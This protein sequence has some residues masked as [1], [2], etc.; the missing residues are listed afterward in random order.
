VAAA[1]ATFPHTVSLPHQ[2][3]TRAA[4]LA[5]L[6]TAAVIHFSCHG[7]AVPGDPLQSSLLLAWDEQLTLADLLTR[8]LQQ[9]R[10]VVLSA[11]QTALP[12]AELLDEVVSLP[13]TL[14]QA[15]AA[16]AIGSLWSVD[17]FATA[18]L[19]GRFYALWRR[20]E[21]CSLAAALQGA[22]A[23]LRALTPAERDAALGFAAS[24]SG[25]PDPHPYAGPHWWAGF[26]LTGA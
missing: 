23:W 8:Q 10:L 22:Q 11:C 18:L 20:G 12:G 15:G 13:A 14:L 24:R 4:V 21:G 6:D 9:T 26:I 19:L 16:A 2:R 25:D 1:A 17:D 7:R 3:A 5:E